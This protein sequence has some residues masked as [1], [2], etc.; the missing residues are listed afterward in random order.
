[1]L[2]LEPA[3][4]T[5]ADLVADV[6]DDQLDG[7]TPCPGTSVGAM[8]DHMAGFALAFTAAANHTEPPGGSRPP[9]SS[10]SRLVAD[11]RTLIPAR[12]AE[13]ADAWRVKAAWSGVT[14]A[15]GQELPSEIAGVIALDEVVVHGWDLALATG[16][17]YAVEAPLL[18]A[19]YGF[20][21]GSAEQNPQGTP[22]LFG[23]PIFLPDDAPLLDRVIGLAGRDPNWAPTST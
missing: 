14:K 22:G 16:Q 23:P 4:R 17:P 2:D 6:R 3:T 13:L 7:P 21:R 15:G 5:L 18:E 20:V 1:M 9:S 8:L 19:V 10:A 11:W 12:L